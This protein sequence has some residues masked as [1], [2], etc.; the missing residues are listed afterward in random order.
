MSCDNGRDRSTRIMLGEG[1]KSSRYGG[2]GSIWTGR[3]LERGN[4][5]VGRQLLAGVKA[6]YREAIVCEGGWS[7]LT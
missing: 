2:K 4:Y 1:I 3:I 7:E 5:G 6:F